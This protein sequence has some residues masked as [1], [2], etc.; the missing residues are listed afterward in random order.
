L[1][2]NNAEDEMKELTSGERT[3]STILAAIAFCITGGFAFLSLFILEGI[4]IW[5][6]VVALAIALLFG[7][8]LFLASPRT[9]AGFMRWFPW[10]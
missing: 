4:P 6:R 8:V 2:I 9:R 5:V 1:G 10:P 3:I 7:W